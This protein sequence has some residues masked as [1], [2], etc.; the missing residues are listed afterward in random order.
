MKIRQSR[1]TLSDTY[2]DAL[3]IRKTVFVDEQRV[4]LAIEI[5]ENEA[6]CLHF[7]LYNELEQACATCR[8]LPD[9]NQQSVTLQRMAV[10]KEHRG[11]SL[12]QIL[13]Q[14]VIAFC[15]EQG[16]TEIVLHAQTTA[17]DFYQK[18]GFNEVGDIF[19]E[20]GIDHITMSKTL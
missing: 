20:A 16:F 7:V 12:G 3:A 11:Q 14:E 1:N 9:K 6:L 4:P 18:E 2:L 15:Q 5:D 19:Q 10:L 8:I 17:R 13:I